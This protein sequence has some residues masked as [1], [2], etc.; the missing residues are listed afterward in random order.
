M[1]QKL[2]VPLDGSELA[3]KAIAAATEL[4]QRFSS[5]IMLLR[6]VE[7]PILR[8]QRYNISFA[9]MLNTLRQSELKE[10]ERYLQQVQSSLHGQGIKAQ[11][12]IAEGEPVAEQI[13]QQV[14]KLGADTIVMC[15]RGQSGL[16]R[17]V[18]GSVADRVLRYAEVPVVLVRGR[19]THPTPP[20]EIT[21][22]P[23][24]TFADIH[25]PALLEGDEGAES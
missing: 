24:E 14:E 20:A 21:I 12:V 16:R 13:L 7:A 8:S 4:A 6:V 1:F 22:P 11:M 9:E 19:E 15:T 25:T 18:Y 2:L 23:I 17:W 3:E 5:Q 10:A